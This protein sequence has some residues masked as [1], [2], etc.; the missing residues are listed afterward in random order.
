MER[1]GVDMGACFSQILN[2]NWTQKV[3]NNTMHEWIS[4]RW[5]EKGDDDFESFR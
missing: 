4:E 3:P 5:D 1:S 2:L